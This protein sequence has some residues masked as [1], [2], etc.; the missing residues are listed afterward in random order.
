VLYTCLDFGLK[1]LHPFMPFITEE[2]YHRLPGANVVGAGGRT[3]CGSI[4]V[5]VY[6]APAHTQ[7]FHSATLD[8]T[9]TMLQDIAHSARSTRSALNITKQRLN[10]HIKCGNA[11]IYE[12]VKAHAKDISVMA[13]AADT[14]ALLR[15]AHT[16]HTTSHT[17]LSDHH[18]RLP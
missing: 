7:A 4:M 9:M 16:H 10:M 5:A 15:Y 18:H 13:V 14:F 2:L 6:P 1:L 3:S 17:P 11:T 8:A 12:A